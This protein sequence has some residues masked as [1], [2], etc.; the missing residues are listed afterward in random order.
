MHFRAIGFGTPRAPFTCRWTNGAP[1]ASYKIQWCAQK[2]ITCNYQRTFY[3]QAIC[4]CSASG[5]F[6]T[7]T[8]PAVTGNNTFMAT[9][10]VAGTAYVFQVAQKEHC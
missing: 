6:S 5:G 3:P 4:T 8:Q 7:A 2:Y 10:L 9:G 1:I